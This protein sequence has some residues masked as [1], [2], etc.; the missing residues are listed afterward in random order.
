MSKRRYFPTHK[1]LSNKYVGSVKGETLS[2]QNSGG[3]L[4]RNRGRL[5]NLEKSLIE[6]MVM[7]TPHELTRQQVDAAAM[8][9]KRSR[10][11]IKNHVAK[12]K[13]AL[14]RNASRYVD[15]HLEA[16]ET[17]LANGDTDTARKAAEFAL[18]HISASDDDGT[19]A[20]I[21]APAAAA[22]PAGPS[23]RIGIALGGMRKQIDSGLPDNVVDAETID[24]DNTQ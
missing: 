14:Q 12:A 24:S 3:Q 19:V 11:A 17:A 1:P 6:S 2:N 23:I 9:L 7:N 18:K 22:A 16:A 13:E 20:L 21:D 8:M 15:L 4:G 5:T 10:Q